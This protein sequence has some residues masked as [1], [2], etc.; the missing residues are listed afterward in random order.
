MPDAGF[1]RGAVR[2]QL[3][4]DSRGVPRSADKQMKYYWFLAVRLRFSLDY[5]C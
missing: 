5:L 2:L 3:A 4:P 1:Q